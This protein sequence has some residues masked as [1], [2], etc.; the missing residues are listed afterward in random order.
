MET[1]QTV[2]NKPQQ[3]SE[4][5]A[6][7]LEPTPT[8][9]VRSERQAVLG[10]SITI[11]GSLSGEEDLLIE[12]RVEGEVS[13]GQ[14]A[15][16]VGKR[17]RVDADLFCKRVFVEGQVNGNLHGDELVVIR[18]SGRV[19][20][21]AE[22]PRVCLEEGAWFRGKIDTEPKSATKTTSNTAKSSLDKTPGKTT[23]QS[24]PASPK[25]GGAA[26]SGEEASSDS[27]KK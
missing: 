11:R 19:K 10:P 5:P 21:N 20:G 23:S 26:T 7:S 12:G 15:V 25:L 13:F 3:D 22:A 16:T 8:E 2:W 24:S 17:G 27:R 14:H 1:G 9:P 6:R 4:A 18:Q